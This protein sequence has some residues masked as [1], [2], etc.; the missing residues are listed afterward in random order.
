MVAMGL[1]VDLVKLS[2]FSDR[3][4]SNASKSLRRFA[5]F[6]LGRAVVFLDK[7]SQLSVTV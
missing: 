3:P 4:G 2:L 6:L 5:V 1:A 7:G